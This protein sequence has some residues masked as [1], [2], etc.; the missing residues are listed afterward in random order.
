M[1]KTCRIRL[2]S[3]SLRPETRLGSSL[4]ILLTMRVDLL[5]SS[6]RRTARERK[7]PKEREERRKGRKERKRRATKRR[8][9]RRERRRVEREEKKPVGTT[10]RVSRWFHPCLYLV[11]RRHHLL[12][13]RYG[14]REMRQKISNRSMMLN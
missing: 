9:K 3:G 10:K 4:T 1:G 2:D 11:L 7:V 5:L 6:K 13:K 14:S 8:R 12:T